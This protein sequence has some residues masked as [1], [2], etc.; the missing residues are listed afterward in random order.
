MVVVLGLRVLFK[1]EECILEIT[2]T[3]NFSY[4]VSNV[5]ISGSIDAI[6]KLVAR[7]AADL[8]SDIW[9]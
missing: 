8:D 5:K 7:M 4:C 2:F 6:N 1:W 3:P 9:K